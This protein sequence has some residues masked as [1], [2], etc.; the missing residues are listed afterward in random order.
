[1][2]SRPF[3]RAAGF[4]EWQPLHQLTDLCASLELFLKARNAV[5]DGEI[6]CLDEN[7]HSQSNE[8]LFRRGAP[9]FCAFDLLWLNGRDLRGGGGNNGGLEPPQYPQLVS[10]C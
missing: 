3:G 2:P 8:L 4:A 10:I 5:L 7:G 9:Q 6:V 1:M